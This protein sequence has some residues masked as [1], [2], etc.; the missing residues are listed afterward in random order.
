MYI[1]VYTYI[2]IYIQDIIYYMYKKYID[3]SSF[4]LHIQDASLPLSKAEWMA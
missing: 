2:H 3:T 4:V 1:Y